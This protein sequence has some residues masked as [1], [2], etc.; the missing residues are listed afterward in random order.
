MNQMKATEKVLTDPAPVAEPLAGIPGGMSFTVRA[1]TK[2][3][4]YWD[5]YFE[6]MKTIPKALGEAG[7][8]GPLPAYKIVEDK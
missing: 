3:E 4:H 5:V 2:T 6:L 8:G 7:V 1:W